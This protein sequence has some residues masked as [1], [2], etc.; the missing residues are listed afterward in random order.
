MP[1]THEKTKLSMTKK[2]TGHQ[3]P[4][5]PSTLFSNWI[6]IWGFW[7]QKQVSQAG[8]SNY[9]SQFT[10]GC[11]Y[12]YPPQI[13]AS[14]AKVLIYKM[15]SMVHKSLWSQPNKRGGSWWPG[16]YFAPGHLQPRHDDV[17]RPVHVIV[18]Q[19]WD[20]MGNNWMVYDIHM[21][22]LRE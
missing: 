21:N 10:V 14:G 18:P 19:P 20:R 9:I 4:D 13:P 5:S 22:R 15:R 2:P 11:N 3:P 6:T 7:H 12:L 1:Q 8:I 17:G 16:D